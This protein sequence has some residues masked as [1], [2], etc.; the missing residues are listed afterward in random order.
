MS[1]LEHIIE[2]AGF[3][4]ILEAR[5]HQGIGKLILVLGKDMIS[6]LKMYKIRGKPSMILR[7][8]GLLRMS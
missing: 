3:Q 4:A 5:L 7:N 2:G 8:S 6:Q 1:L